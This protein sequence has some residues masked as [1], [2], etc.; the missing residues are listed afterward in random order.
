MG[1]L[2]PEAASHHATDLGCPGSCCG[3]G[4]TK[5]RKQVTMPGGV[6]QFVLLSGLRKET[7]RRDTRDCQR[8]RIET[9]GTG[10]VNKTVAGGP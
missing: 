8:L 6:G 7:G 3:R 2:A 10:N 1:A 4:D 9:P 5:T